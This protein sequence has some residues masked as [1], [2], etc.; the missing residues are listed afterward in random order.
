[1]TEEP[2]DDESLL[3]RA[4]IRPTRQR[5][6]LVGLL[7]RRQGITHF[8]ALEVFQMLPGAGLRLSQGTIYH[9]LNDLVGAGLLRR[10]GIGDKSLYCAVAAPHHHFLDESTGQ[11]TDI[12]GS[13]PTITNLPDPPEGMAISDVEVIVRLRRL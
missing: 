9:T 7:L 1:M 2:L 10:I 5:L 11:V 4:G 13:L 3:R 12:P 8:T 6:A